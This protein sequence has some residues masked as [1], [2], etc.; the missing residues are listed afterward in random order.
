MT[1]AGGR[2]PRLRSLLF[3]LLICVALLYLGALGWLKWHETEM[4]YRP[5]TAM[6]DVPGDLGIAPERLQVTDAAG[7]THPLWVYR[8]RPSAEA[9][10]VI[11]L[12]GNG[13]NVST[14]MNVARCHQ[15]TLLGLNVVAVEYPGFGESPGVPSEPGMVAAGMA[16]W[17][18]LTR[19]LGV[20]PSRV[21][22]YG[23][24]LGSGAATQVA[25]DV[26]EAAVV[27]EGAFTSVA[28][29][30]AEVY[31]YLPVRW[32]LRHPFASSARIG[33]ASSPLLLL[34]ARDDEI[35]PFAHAERLQ[36]AARGLRHLVP[37]AGGHVYPNL[38]REDDYLH[39]LHAFLGA[40]LDDVTLTRPPR[41]LVVRL[42]DASEAGS[43]AR[44]DALAFA[45]RV[46]AG[47]DTGFN[48]ASYAWRYAVRR[49]R[50]VDV[51]DADA[52]AAVAQ[53]P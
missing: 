24:S 38:A 2:R 41:S 43:A 25:A 31:P 17:H 22:L 14:S 42:L 45:E 53:R 12:H 19:D 49:W 15:L 29:V 18:W 9:G 1:A 13:A 51:A 50:S 23:W 10:W 52:L 8:T 34:H 28:D 3:G 37:L 36:Q 30:A 20:S 4:I 21:A 6:Q 27:L 11:F 33:Q 47:R 7:A 5:V 40:A 48:A 32:L 26:D 39:A 44:A 16:A 46:A 35:V